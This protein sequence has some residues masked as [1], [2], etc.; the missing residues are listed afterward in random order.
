MNLIVCATLLSV[1]LLA[2]SRTVT[3]TEMSATGIRTDVV[4]TEQLLDD[5]VINLQGTW[6][7]AVN[8]GNFDSDPE[9]EYVC[10]LSD[11]GQQNTFIT[12][13]VVLDDDL[14]Q[15]WAQT[16]GYQGNPEPSS[17]TVA[18]LDLDGRD[19]II[20]PMCETFFPDQPN[21]K[22]RVYVVDG[23]TGQ[24]KPGWPYIFPGWPEDPYNDIYSEVAAAD[25]DGDDTLEILCVTTDFNSV[26]KGGPSCYALSHRG[27]SLWRYEFYK[28]DTI[29]QHGCWTGP[30]VCDL[31]GDRQKEIIC[32]VDLHSP[33]NPWPLLER[34][35]FIIESDGTIRKQF[36][37]EGAGSAQSTNYASPVVADVNGD[38]APEIVLLRRT[39]FLDVFDTSGTRLSGYP[40]DLTADAG[41]VSGLYTKAFSSPAV[42]D[43]VDDDRPEIVIG[44]FGMVQS[45]ADWGG[46]IHAFKPDGCALPGFPVETR[47][48]IWHSP[49]IGNVDSLPG[50]EILTAGC[51]SSF[52]VV[53]SA[54]ESLP[55]YPVRDFPTYFLPDEGNMGFIEGKIPLC[56]TPYLADADS[57]GLTEILVQGSDGAFH[58]WD[59]DATFAPDQLPWPTC[60]LDKE[61]TGAPYAPPSGVAGP[62]RT[63]PVLGRGPTLVR[64]ILRLPGKTPGV[65]LDIT[66]RSVTDLAPGLNDLRAVAPG[67]YFVQTAASRGP[68]AVRKVVIP[69]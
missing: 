16:W 55:G 1:G 6:G 60:R 10:R 13:I 42:V 40:V 32:H 44:S 34:R 23:E 2:P 52:Y 57:D 3:R 59:T 50:F 46:H 37:T 51:D 22:C 38:D 24:V 11:V 14:S 9:M 30:A 47:N 27:D 19:E 35:L 28:D 7:L 12:R 66:G 68:S 39:G 4:S 33:N 54:G 69:D 29:N 25:I 21:Y 45:G 36:Q 31:D 63:E 49:G 61:R 56:K 67:V 65:L 53:S 26:R 62:V 58:L 15:L 43:I 41:Y 64:G 5:T 48:A 8:G 20:I 17:P 18:D